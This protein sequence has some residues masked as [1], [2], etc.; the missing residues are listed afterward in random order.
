MAKPVAA[1]VPKAELQILPGVT[2]YTFLSTCN[3]VGRTVAKQICVDPEGVD[4]AAVHR[5]VSTDALRFFER[6]LR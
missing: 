4:R 3:S 6:S 2:H 5:E 1:L